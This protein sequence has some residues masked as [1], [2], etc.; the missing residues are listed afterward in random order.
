MTV[1]EIFV[2][3]NVPVIEENGFQF[4]NPIKTVDT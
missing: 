2:G 4:L 1:K 3:I